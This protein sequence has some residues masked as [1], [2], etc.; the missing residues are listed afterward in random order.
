MDVLLR[1]TRLVARGV[2]FYLLDM[3]SDTVAYAVSA[4]AAGPAQVI[5]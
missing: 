1:A 4:L 2:P 5:D 3:L